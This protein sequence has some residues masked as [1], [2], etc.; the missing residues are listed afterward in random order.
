MQAEPLTTRAY[1]PDVPPGRLELPT[2]TLGTSRALRLRYEGI[3]RDEGL[4]PPQHKQPGYN[5]PRLSNVG[6]PAWGDW[7]ELNRRLR[8]HDPA[9]CH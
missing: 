5:R 6:D 9:L 1:G 2:S 3:V 4:E 8:D 7:P